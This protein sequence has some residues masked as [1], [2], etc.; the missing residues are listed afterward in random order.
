M[1]RSLQLQ[2]DYPDMEQRVVAEDSSGSLRDNDFDLAI[3][4]NEL[5]HCPLLHDITAWLGS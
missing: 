4:L 2:A 3:A 5:V 1:P